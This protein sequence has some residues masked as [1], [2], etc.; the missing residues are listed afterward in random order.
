VTALMP[1]TDHGGKRLVGLETS[2]RGALAS[3][4]CGRA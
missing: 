4:D 1:A 2:R 3:V